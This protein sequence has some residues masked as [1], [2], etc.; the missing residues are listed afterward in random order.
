MT[1][2]ASYAVRYL[3][4]IIHGLERVLVIKGA[5]MGCAGD[6]R[7]AAPEWSRV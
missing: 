2:G 5:D 1:G 4:W 3:T 6:D 7:R